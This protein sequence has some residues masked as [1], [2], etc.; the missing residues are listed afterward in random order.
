MTFGV[1]TLILFL[2]FCGLVFCLQLYIADNR[3]LA[4]LEDGS[5][6]KTTSERAGDENGLFKSPKG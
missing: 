6:D 3:T 4:H 5:R 2:Y 1:C